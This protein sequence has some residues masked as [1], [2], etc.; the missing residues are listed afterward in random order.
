MLI[1]VSSFCMPILTVLFRIQLMGSREVTNWGGGAL[2]ITSSLSPCV[3][4]QGE[5]PWLDGQSLVGHLVDEPVGV[6]HS[7]A[8]P[9]TH[10]TKKPHVFQLR[11]ADW[12][13]Y[14]FQAP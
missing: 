11:T 14:L 3:W 2:P 8:S 4:W 5:G 9:A 1:R 12:R 7:L 6:H 13:L 10:Y